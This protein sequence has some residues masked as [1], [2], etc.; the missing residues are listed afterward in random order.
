MPLLVLAEHDRH[1]GANAVDRPPQVDAERP[2]PVLVVCLP[3][4]NGE[5]AADTGVV[6]QDVDLAIGLECSI[7]QMLDGLESDTSVSTPITSCPCCLRMAD[8][9]VRAGCSTSARTTFMPALRA[10]RVARALP[11][12]LAAPV[13][14]RDT[15]SEVL[16]S[17]RA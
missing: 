14:T 7:A 10:K 2:L 16:P 6:A 17:C 4:G 8:R 15:A 12:P 9:L 13:T 1:K 3:D 11:I 5:Q